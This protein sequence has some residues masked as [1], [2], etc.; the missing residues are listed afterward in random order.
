MG[1]MAQLTDLYMDHLRALLEGPAD[2]EN[3]FVNLA[4][5]GEQFRRVLAI[6]ETPSPECVALIGEYDRRLAEYDG[7]VSLDLEQ[8]LQGA[9]ND[10]AAYAQSRR[11]TRDPNIGEEAL[12]GV[13]QLLCLAVAACRAGRLSPEAIDA[14][15]AKAQGEVHRLLPLLADLFALADTRCLT[16]G[17]DSEFPEL[18]SFWDELAYLAPARLEERALAARMTPEERVKAPR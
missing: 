8:D 5:T 6:E 14:L 16:W 13:D 18:Y 10:L 12:I 4:V 9:L 3:D 7:P 17:P 1:K 11:L 2:H 15:G